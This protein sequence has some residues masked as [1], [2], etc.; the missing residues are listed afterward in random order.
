[1]RFIIVILSL[2]LLILIPCHLIGQTA[3]TP[4]ETEIGID[5]HLDDYVPLDIMV[6]DEKTRPQTWLP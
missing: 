6:I 2:S 4:Q 1:M 3:I 5:E